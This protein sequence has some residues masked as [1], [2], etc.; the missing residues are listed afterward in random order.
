MVTKLYLYYSKAWWYE[1]GLT[2]GDFEMAG[3]AR[4]MLLQGKEILFFEG[5]IGFTFKKV[6]THVT[7]HGR[8]LS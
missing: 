6:F 1:L 3:D 2:D 8:S 7:F 4:N 5:R